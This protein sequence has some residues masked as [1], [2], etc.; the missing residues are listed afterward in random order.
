[1]L[2]VAPSGATTLQLQALSA[3]TVTAGAAVT[4]S[5]A[6][7]ASV[8]P[9]AAALDAAAGVAYALC[10]QF[11]SA[12]Q[13]WVLAFNASTGVVTGTY[14][15]SARLF[16]SALVVVPPAAPAPSSS[17]GSL[18]LALA[19]DATG[20]LAVGSVDVVGN[21][22]WTRLA[23]ATLP[24]GAAVHVPGAAASEAPAGAGLLAFGVAARDGTHAVADV[25]RDPT[26]GTSLTPLT[27][28]GDVF[29]RLLLKA[30]PPVNTTAVLAAATAALSSGNLTASSA[31]LASAASALNELAA[32][33]VTAATAARVVLI[34]LLAATV[35][36]AGS[37]LGADDAASIA[38]SVAL[39]LGVPAASGGGVTFTAGTVIT[40]P[41]A[42]V[43]AALGTLSA[44][45]AAAGLSA[46]AVNSI[47]AAAAALV[48]NPAALPLADAQSAMRLLST[49]AASAELS[50]GA[51]NAVAAALSSVL[52]APAAAG[53]TT[54]AVKAGAAVVSMGAALAG[55]PVCVAG[56][57][58]SSVDVA[59]A[60]VNMLISRCSDLNNP[61][62]AAAALTLPSGLGFSAAPASVAASTSPVHTIL[63][64]LA[65]DPHTGLPNTTGIISLTFVDG[66]TN[67]ALNV[68]GLSTLLYFDLPTLILP[69][70]TSALGTFWDS[71]ATPPSYATAGV[72]AMP[73][74]TPAG[75]T[76]DWAPG[77]DA[78]ALPLA[79][80]WTL[81][82]PAL[83]KCYQSV[84]DCSDAT[85]FN[86][87]FSLDPMN[88][89]GGSVVQCGDGGAPKR[90]IY[91]T[92]CALWRP[93]PAG[94]YWD[95]A[96][97]A[98][99]GSG[100]VTASVTRM[101]TRHLTDFLAIPTIAVA[102][103]SDLTLSISDLVH[104]RFLIMVVAIVFGGMLFG[105]ALLS[106]RDKRDA[107]L[108]LAAVQSKA[109]GFASAGGLWTWRLSQEPLP[110][111][112]GSAVELAALLGLPF[113]R[114]AC[115]IPEAMLGVESLSAAVGRHG[116][117]SAAAL[118]ATVRIKRVDLAEEDGAVAAVQFDDAFPEAH[119]PDAQMKMKEPGADDDALGAADVAATASAALGPPTLNELASTALLHAVMLSYSICSSVDVAAQQVLYI[120]R[121][122]A[123][124]MS[125][126]HFLRAFGI[127][128]ELMRT[129]VLR[130]PDNWWNLA[131]LV[132]A[133]LLVRDD[134]SW[135]AAGGI[136]TTL[137]ASSHEQPHVELRGLA[138]LPA[139]AQ[140]LVA[141]SVSAYIGDTTEAVDE[142]AEAAA[143]AKK[144]NQDSDS[145]DG[146]AASNISAISLT[147]SFASDCPLA[148]ADAAVVEALPESLRAARSAAG[149]AE[150]V[151][152]TAC[153]VAAL[154]SLPAGW[155][156]DGPEGGE[157]I[158]LA[159]AGHA[160]LERRLDAELLALATTE[161]AAATARWATWHSRRV[162]A[163]RAH[164]VPTAEHASAV[165][166]RALGRVVHSLLTRHPTLG[167]FTS[168][169][170]V[171]TQRW[172]SF[173]LIV[174]ALA[175]VLTTSIWL[176]YSRAVT[177]A[178]ALRESLG[179]VASFREPCHGYSGPYNQLE[180]T[181]YRLGG[182]G[183]AG[184]PGALP[185]AVCTAFPD[186]GSHRDTFLTGLIAAAAA[187]V[188]TAFAGVCFDLEHSTDEAQLRGR[189]RLRRWPFTMRLLLGAPPWASED[190]DDATE[191]VK[192]TKLALTGEWLGSPLSTAVV[193]A[194]TALIPAGS[195]S[196]GT[197]R[198]A[199]AFER[200]LHAYRLFGIAAVAACWAIMLWL[201]F[202]Y[203]TLV[204][205]LL[206]EAATRA[207]IT[208]WGVGVGV[209]QVQDFKS[210]LLSCAET[211][212]A[213]SILEVAWLQSNAT[214]FQSNV[215]YLSVLHTLAAEQ[216]RAG[217]G[218]RFIS[219]YA[220][221]YKG[222][223]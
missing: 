48:S 196:G 177:C 15:L 118:K 78:S 65:F 90:I 50:G 190:D 11:G 220:R 112:S 156:V 117:M 153:V 10:G 138:A 87:L 77:F 127:F 24:A 51:A 4:P 186:P 131:R 45:S 142:L 19:L 43:T 85:Q 25:A 32:T 20:S 204:Y 152:S 140:R 219:A 163:S 95:N 16:V 89:L 185:P 40:L 88:H 221:F 205:D 126:A 183:L 164:H 179:C 102:S 99:A 134:G 17:G 222:V 192:R 80:A 7:A 148:F 130:A 46:A 211:L 218:M 44:A 37:S 94:C 72:V 57:A 53:V 76:L 175:A 217:T 70:G 147:A 157:L 2:C 60:S 162:T 18:L 67:R 21:A 161:A 75:L 135:E 184:L 202:V 129:S 208:S 120:A 149:D 169:A 213:L 170:M 41:P 28:G 189:V 39:L 74:P 38:L 133:A 81:S 154:R 160:W 158:S 13:Q 83:A 123:A 119:Q 42:V 216:E 27:P 181:L 3:G 35:E 191:R 141:A 59:S 128:K 96:A 125:S 151:W 47:A 22:G 178:S 71:S 54:I 79:F 121:L 73:N 12:S 124:G 215:E 206:G 197:V 97:Q 86:Q 113:A 31:A 100:C 6:C 203:G 110:G 166:R 93:N 168:E 107:R 146:V 5:P 91:G 8:Q 101:A 172:Q 9:C 63:Y 139:K 115:S 195:A 167:V 182:A 137:L 98:F 212:L 116:G 193:C 132:R 103:T 214:W 201:I 82:G 122:E 143:R 55:G 198:S 187:Y 56:A 150:R 61:A 108:K 173:L 62:A 180:E 136:A 171:S 207:F 1:M 109:M 188:V 30:S 29:L 52:D 145:S 34:T 223:A 176:Y 33:N 114:L 104:I 69:G 194:T 14:P 159:D 92:D 105:S 174:T 49:V 165:L 36:S 155:Y 199:H 26:T 64:S 66:S 106:I 58:A 144:A 68:S 23:T 200:L 111:V 210:L 84:L 209:A